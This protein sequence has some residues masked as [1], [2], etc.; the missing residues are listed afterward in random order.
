MQKILIGLRGF[1]MYWRHR[2]HRNLS[3]DKLYMLHT[4][5][6]SKHADELRQRECI[7]AMDEHYFG[8]YLIPCCA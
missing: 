8:V 4:K 3:V 7:K 1:V 5:Q 6:A 2:N